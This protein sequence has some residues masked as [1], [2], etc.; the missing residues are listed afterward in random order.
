V[1][2]L[3]RAVEG[4]RGE[5]VHLAPAP[6][7]VEPGPHGGAVVTCGGQRIGVIETVEQVLAMIGVQSK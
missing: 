5:P 1:I 6:L 3:H 4:R 7:I 2:T